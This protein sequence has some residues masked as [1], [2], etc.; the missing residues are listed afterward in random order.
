M[1]QA[2]LLP[3]LV[4]ASVARGKVSQFMGIRMC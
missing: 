2:R 1:N 4:I 3:V